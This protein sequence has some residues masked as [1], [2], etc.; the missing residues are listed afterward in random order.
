MAIKKVKS[1]NASTL[2]SKSSISSI[3]TDNFINKISVGLQSKDIIS[4]TN[5]LKKL[6]MSEDDKKEALK[7]YNND[8]GSWLESKNA[9][10]QNTGIIINKLQKGFTIKDSIFAFVNKF[11]LGNDIFKNILTQLSQKGLN[12][13]LQYIQESV[14]INPSQKVS[15]NLQKDTK[16]KVNEY[17]SIG[18]ITFSGNIS[19]EEPI[20]IK[21]TPTNC[22]FKGLAS[23]SDTEY[24]NV[25]TLE[26]Q[27]SLDSINTEFAN[28]LIKPLS[29]SDV[30]LSIQIDSD[31]VQEFLF[32]N[33]TEDSK[34]SVSLDTST[35]LTQ[36]SYTEINPILFSGNVSETDP[37]TIKIT[38]TNCK[39][40]GVVSEPETEHSSEYVFNSQIS[41][42]NIN[43]EFASL[44]LNPLTTE[45]V[46][47]SIIIDELEPNE[48]TFTNIT[49]SE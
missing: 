24:D 34:V 11:K 4:I 38:P 25:Y 37:V 43:A 17:T 12:G 23:G 9:I 16:L 20:T 7:T 5:V 13:V 33:V 39:F 47:I 45:D 44:Q 3:S 32:T 18:A 14:T 35:Q 30:K 10:P 26:S 36:N 48:F 29:L 28:I 19:E 8:I 21:I 6:N 1:S 31:S 42:E 15:I 49:P 2:S 27:T 22:K 40:K 46:K 41:L